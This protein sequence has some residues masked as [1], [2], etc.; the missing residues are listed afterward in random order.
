MKKPEHVIPSNNS[1]LN[2]SAGLKATATKRTP[3]KGFHT[4]SLAPPVPVCGEKSG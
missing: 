4:D 3:S 1:G 2:Q